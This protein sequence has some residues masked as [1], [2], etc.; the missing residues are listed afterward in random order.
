MPKAKDSPAELAR[1]ATAKAKARREAEDRKIDAEHFAIRAHSA[2]LDGRDPRTVV[3]AEDCK[4]VAGVEWGSREGPGIDPG[5]DYAEQ[6][7][8]GHP[9]KATN[10]RR[11]AGSGVCWR[12]STQ[13]PERPMQRIV[14]ERDALTA[15]GDRRHILNLHYRR[16]LMLPGV[17]VILLD[18]DLDPVIAAKFF[19]R[20]CGWSRSRCGNRPRSSKF[21]TAHAPCGFCWAAREDDQQ[22]AN[23]RLAEVQRFAGRVLAEG[24]L[25]VCYKAALERMTLPAGVDA[26]H[27][28]NLRGR[29]GYKHHDVAV[30]RRPP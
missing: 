30:V 7:G 1:E 3:T 18:A 11:L 14:L 15:D 24:G 25:F 16:E 29:D 27:L 12:P 23:N 2:L 8:F 6:S 21:A 20:M 5:M 26:V 9:G 13:H 22:R 17:P 10:A 19:G 4:L 28:G